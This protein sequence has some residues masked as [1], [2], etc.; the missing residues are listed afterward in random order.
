MYALKFI[1]ITGDVDKTKQEIDILSK[2]D[3]PYVIEFNKYYSLHDLQ[4][5]IQTKYCLTNLSKIIE[6]KHTFIHQNRGR[7]L[8]LAAII[9]YYI[10]CEILNELNNGIKYLHDNKIMHGDVKPGNVL[11][12][13]D[14]NNGIFCKLCDFGLSKIFDANRNYD[15]CEPDNIGSPKYKAPEDILVF[16]SDIYSLVRIIMMVTY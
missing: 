7:E 15:D 3:S 8:E 13:T 11:I 9:D 1:K 16:K 10:S 5:C 12:D 6:L 14:S 4:C 2:L